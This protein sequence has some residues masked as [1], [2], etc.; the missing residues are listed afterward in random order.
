MLPNKNNFISKA[1]TRDFCLKMKEYLLLLVY[2]I[3]VSNLEFWYPCFA[4]ISFFFW[5]SHQSSFIWPIESTLAFLKSILFC[6]S[7]LL[8]HVDFEILSI[9]SKVLSIQYGVF[10]LYYLFIHVHVA[11]R[12]IVVVVFYT[13]IYKEILLLNSVD[14]HPLRVRIFLPMTT[15]QSCYPLSLSDFCPKLS[16]LEFYLFKC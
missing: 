11:F 14:W 13:R 15:M 9:K 4:C 1:W 10:I 8:T 6:L 2:I 7:S 12:I 5:N 16:L 3:L